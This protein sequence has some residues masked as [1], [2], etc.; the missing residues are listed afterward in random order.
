MTLY[1]GALIAA[2][3]SSLVGQVLLKAGASTRLR[4]DLGL[5]AADFARKAGRDGVLKMIETAAS[6]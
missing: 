3:T 2:I 1:W 5:T 4:N 6:K